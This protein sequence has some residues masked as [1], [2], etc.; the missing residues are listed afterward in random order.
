MQSPKDG[1]TVSEQL[2][3]NNVPVLPAHW[4]NVNSQGID[5]RV[6]HFTSTEVN[7]QIHYDIGE[8]AGE[9]AAAKPYPNHQW[10]KSGTL[11]GSSFNYLL[12]DDGILYVTFPD[13]GPANFWAK[14]S[15]DTDIDYV[16]EL[17]ARY[18]EQLLSGNAAS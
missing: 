7:Y 12:N 5:S 13:E 15:T 18:R 8:L 14:V 3:L 10:I 4:S 17:L 16:L 11:H 1:A 6:G 9:Y 2:K